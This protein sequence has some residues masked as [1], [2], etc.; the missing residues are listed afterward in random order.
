MRHWYFDLH[1]INCPAKVAVSH[2]LGYLQF[3]PLPDIFLTPSSSG[4]L[5]S[6]GR[7][8]SDDSTTTADLPQ[9]GALRPLVAGP[10]QDQGERTRTALQL[11]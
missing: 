11:D 6:T 10:R 4:D 1:H 2:N 7:N 5:F 8:L 9:L 3:N